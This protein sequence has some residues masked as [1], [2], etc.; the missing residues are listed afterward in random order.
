MCVKLKKDNFFTENLDLT[1][2]PLNSIDSS[3][4]NVG[5]IVISNRNIAFKKKKLAVIV[6]FRDCFQELQTFVP[7]MTKFLNDQKIPHHIFIVSQVDKFRFNRAAL[8][9]VGFLY[10]RNKF[11]YLVIHDIDLIPLNKNLSYECPIEGVSHVLA[12]WLRPINDY[13][14]SELCGRF[15]N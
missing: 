14:V 7:Y 9:N 12:P 5:N 3:D 8:I 6:P 2:N 10:A 4:F 1:E 15:N 11:D 13:R